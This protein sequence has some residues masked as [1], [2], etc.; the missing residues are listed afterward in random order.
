[1]LDNGK[2]TNKI[3]DIMENETKFKEDLELV[4]TG[5]IISKILSMEQDL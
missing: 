5:R 1:M 4:E 3:K 2:I